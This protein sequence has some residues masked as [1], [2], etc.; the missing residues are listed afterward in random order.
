MNGLSVAKQDAIAMVPSWQ[1]LALIK[2]PLDPR[3]SVMNGMPAIH[4][5]FP[6]NLQLSYFIDPTVL[7]TSEYSK[8][9][10]S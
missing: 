2:T 9:D 10:F 4:V 5:L 3:D 7:Q 8:R 6:L 1:Y